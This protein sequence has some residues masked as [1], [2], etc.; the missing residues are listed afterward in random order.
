MLAHLTPSLACSRACSKGD[1]TPVAFKAAVS[2]PRNHDTTNEVLE[3][4]YAQ[5]TKWFW[6][7][8]GEMSS[9]DKQLMLKFMSGNMRINQGTKYYINIEGTIDSFPEG[10]TCGNSMDIP[11]YSTKELMKQRMQTAFR[12][13][14]EI[15][16]DGDIMDHNEYD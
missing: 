8:F 6:E 11:F 9:E 2:M 10:H 4:K 15:D 7:I 1:I 13:C 5:W 12:L 14:G 3:A 16:L